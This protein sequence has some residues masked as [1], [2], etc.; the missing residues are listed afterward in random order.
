MARMARVASRVAQI[1]Q[2]NLIDVHNFV[3]RD[4][5]RMMEMEWVDGYDLRRIMVPEMLGNVEHRVSVKR[6][7]YI[8]SVIVTAGP[9]QPRIKP[10]V[11]VAAH[12]EC[13]GR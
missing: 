1:Q 11:A 10:G 12:R 3:E 13:E 6:W 7:E 8:N 2:D 4:R 9:I 5:I